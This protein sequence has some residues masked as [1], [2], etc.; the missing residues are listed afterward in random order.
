AYF[1]LFWL[2][3]GFLLIVI[4]TI[5]WIAYRPAPSATRE[6]APRLTVIIP[7]Y[8]E[9]AMVLQSIESVA[10]A[11]YPH[12]RLEILVV[13]DG[14]KDDTWS[15]ISQAAARYPGLVKIGRASCRERV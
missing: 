3:L 12:D 2:G 11:D 13:D 14:S 9:G 15:Y 7:A 5:L 1:G 10:K 4:R 8:N 6:G